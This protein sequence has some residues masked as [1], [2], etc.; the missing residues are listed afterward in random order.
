MWIVAI[1]AALLAL[2]LIGLDRSPVVW[3]D[4]VT[5]VQLAARAPVPDDDVWPP[6]ARGRLVRQCLGTVLNETFEHLGFCVRD[7][8]LIAAQDR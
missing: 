4:E 2:N 6:Y 7:L 1:P 3:L 8:D 5:A